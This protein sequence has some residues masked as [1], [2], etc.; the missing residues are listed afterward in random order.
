MLES[1]ALIQ[2]ALLYLCTC[3]LVLCGL[4]SLHSVQTESQDS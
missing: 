1:G 2:P 3:V 4:Y